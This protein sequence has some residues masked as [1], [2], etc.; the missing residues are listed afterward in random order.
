MFHLIKQEYRCSKNILYLKNNNNYY[1]KLTRI[2]A[3]L[4]SRFFQV[5][6]KGIKDLPFF[7][8]IGFENIVIALFG[9]S[10]VPFSLIFKVLK[11]ASS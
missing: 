11:I 7:H 6:S 1:S 4:L 8:G 9:V 2:M 10:I 3:I 5:I